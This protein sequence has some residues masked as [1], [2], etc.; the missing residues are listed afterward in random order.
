MLAPSEIKYKLFLE[1]HYNIASRKTCCILFQL[2][3]LSFFPGTFSVVCCFSPN[4]RCSNHGLI[5]DK[6]RRTSQSFVDP[7]VVSSLEEYTCHPT[8]KYFSYEEMEAFICGLIPNNFDQKHQS[9]E[10]LLPQ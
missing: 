2:I 1:L 4:L 6:A 5:N 10:V 9:T 8:E 7:L 3:Q